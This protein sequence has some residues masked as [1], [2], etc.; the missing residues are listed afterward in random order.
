MAIIECRGYVSKPK[1]KKTAGGKEYSEF[2]L[3]VKQKKKAYQ[4][5]PEEITW[6]NF[7]VIDY[8]N[9][10]PPPD[11]SFVTIKGYFNVREY[12]KDGQRKSI[13]EIKATELEVSAA[14]SDA[15]EPQPTPTVA[16][17]VAKEPWDPE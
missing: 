5:K 3:G 1:A 2:R 7:S 14:F 13:M 17:T 4:D 6:A 10:S 15:A 11:K 16:G 12:E 9:S 8:T